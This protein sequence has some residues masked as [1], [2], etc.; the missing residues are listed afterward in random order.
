MPR[1]ASQPLDTALLKLVR[2]G[3]ESR[4]DG[5]YTRPRDREAASPISRYIP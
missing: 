4:A 2:M 1:T 3:A 5:W